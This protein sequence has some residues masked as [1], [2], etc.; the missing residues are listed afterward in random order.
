M[1]ST[2]LVN[3]NKKYAIN[4]IISVGTYNLTLKIPVYKHYFSSISSKLV[5]QITN[6]PTR[7]ENLPI[8]GLLA[9]NPLLQPASALYSEEIPKPL[10]RIGRFVIFTAK[11][12]KIVIK[13]LEVANHHSLMT[14]PPPL[15]QI[16]TFS[17]TNFLKINTLPDGT[18]PYLR[19]L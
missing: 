6:I 16:N 5:M 7:E 11:H 8:N 12:C 14:P 2:Q 4:S 10:R 13:R 18:S 3:I 19:Y 15:S 9:L 1:K 17:F